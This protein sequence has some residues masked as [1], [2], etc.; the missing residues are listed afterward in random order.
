MRRNAD[1]GRENNLLVETF[2]LD[3]LAPLFHVDTGHLPGGDLAAAPAVV[4]IVD[5]RMAVSRAAVSADR[6][7]RVNEFGRVALAVSHPHRVELGP[8]AFELV[9][10]VENI[11]VA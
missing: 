5:I 7:Q 1:L 6:I 4:G 2:L 10:F 8:R 3:A 9:N 11:T